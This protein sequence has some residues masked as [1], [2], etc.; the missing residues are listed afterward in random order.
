MGFYIQQ[1]LS[2][3]S[4]AP[5]VNCYCVHAYKSKLYPAKANAYLNSYWYHP[6]CHHAC[7]SHFISRAIFLLCSYCKP[8]CCAPTEIGQFSKYIYFL[9]MVNSGCT[10]LHM[11]K[12]IKGDL[13][14]Y[15]WLPYVANTPEVRQHAMRNVPITFKET[16][17]T[18]EG[19]PCVKIRTHML[20]C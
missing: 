20:R 10:R 4:D 7:P 2:V 9:N 15:F 8:G 1:R 17:G 14:T 18:T 6:A 19:M 13:T 12:A 3:M 16:W 11:Q 5:A